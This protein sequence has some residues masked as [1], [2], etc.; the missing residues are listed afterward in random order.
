MRERGNIGESVYI[1]IL[2]VEVILNT[3]NH[4]YMRLIKFQIT[5][6]ILFVFVLITVGCDG[7]SSEDAIRAK[8]VNIK[9][10]DEKNGFRDIK[11]GSVLGENKNF[12]SLKTDEALGLMT[13]YFEPPHSPLDGDKVVM[14]SGIYLDYKL[15]SVSVYIQSNDLKKYIQNMDDIYGAPSQL[16]DKNKLMWI[17]DKVTLVVSRADFQ[18]D[19][20]NLICLDYSSIALSDK[21]D[22]RRRAKLQE[23][24]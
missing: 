8:N 2:K 11:L 22:K 3:I 23:E 17:G 21:F 6:S 5:L 1:V 4:L 12:V 16:V 24:I 9:R 15:S 19:G 20:E 7:V 13:G 14:I 10:L 18:A